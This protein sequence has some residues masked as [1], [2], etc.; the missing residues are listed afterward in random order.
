MSGILDKMKSVLEISIQN[1]ASE[2]KIPPYLI[3]WE[4]EC[5][6]S[7]PESYLIRIVIEISILNKAWK[8]SKWMIWRQNSVSLNKL[9]IRMSRILDLIKSVFEISIYFYI[10]TKLRFY[11]NSGNW[12]FITVIKFL[13]QNFWLNNNIVH[14]I[15]PGG[16]S[17]ANKESSSP[18]SSL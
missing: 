18:W 17:I 15:Y 8:N 6:E 5:E 16:N 7:D 11:L 3:N 14:K 12:N 2:V 1:K 13:N 9:R 10:I 4:L